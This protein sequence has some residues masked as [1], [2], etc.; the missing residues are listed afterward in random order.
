M[1]K[2]VIKWANDGVL[3]SFCMETRL[4]MDELRFG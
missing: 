4:T 2:C 3:E 1:A